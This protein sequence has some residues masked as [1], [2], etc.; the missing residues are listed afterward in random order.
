MRR[1]TV[2][3]VWVL[4]AAIIIFIVID[5]E[6]LERGGSVVINATYSAINFVV[7]FVPEVIEST[8][9]FISS[10]RE[11]N[12]THEITLTSTTRQQI[13]DIE[14]NNPFHWEMTNFV[15]E[16]A[17][18]RRAPGGISTEEEW[19]HIRTGLRLYRHDVRTVYGRSINGHPHWR[20]TP[21]IIGR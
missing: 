21:I 9:N 8:R 19:T 15:S 11:T 20:P 10:T 13:R 18:S 1:R 3:I 2:S 16:P 14:I 7:T 12:S 6:V 17:T 4:I 5:D